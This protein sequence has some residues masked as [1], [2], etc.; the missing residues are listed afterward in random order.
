MNVLVGVKRKQLPSVWTAM[1]A[2]RRCTAR[3]NT[4]LMS[5]MASTKVRLTIEI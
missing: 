2:A 5:P 1:E 4:A 3:V